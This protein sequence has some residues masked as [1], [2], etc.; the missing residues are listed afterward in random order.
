MVVFASDAGSVAA[1]RTLLWFGRADDQALRT[2][3]S[4]LRDATA[5]AALLGRCTRV[6]AGATDT[7]GL[8][9]VAPTPADWEDEPTESQPTAGPIDPVGSRAD[10]PPE[11]VDAPRNDAMTF[12]DRPTHVQEPTVA[13]PATAPAPALTTE[14]HPSDDALRERLRANPNDLAA[15]EALTGRLAQREDWVGLRDAYTMVIDALGNQSDPDRRLEGVLWQKV[16]GLDVER[17]DAP[18]TGASALRRSMSLRPT[19]ETARLL[20]SALPSDAPLAELYA[21]QAAAPFDAEVV[22]RLAAR[23]DADG[24]WQAATVVHEVAALLRGESAQGGDRIAPSCETWTR[25]LDDTTRLLLRPETRDL[26]LDRLF[27]AAGLAFSSLYAHTA[28]DYELDARNL[29]PPDDPLAIS[30]LV[31]QA[32]LAFGVD[33]EL[34]VYRNVTGFAFAFFERPAFIVGRDLV[35]AIS[36]TEMRFRIGMLMTWTRPYAFLPALLSLSQLSQLVAAV[37][38]WV[39]PAQRIVVTEETQRV[40]RHL[41]TLDASV[42]E[43]L[44]SA[45]EALADRPSDEALEAWRIGLGVEA[46][47]TGALFCGDPATAHASVQEHPPLRSVA[48]EQRWPREVLQW[49]GSEGYVRALTR[50]THTGL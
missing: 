25:A 8:G 35:G 29:L 47:R 23:L 14:A 7:L 21:C 19:R 11:E 49:L 13:L 16:G 30:V 42:S 34:Y 28:A 6:E 46:V 27:T 20:A 5:R 24:S 32:S 26:R 43:R 48:G 15:L 3:A 18:T 39:A 45:V 40:R 33:P 9:T 41:Q 38:D 36:Q 22:D 2:L 10:E 44:R 4:Q 12:S 1:A 50:L 37:C 31:R 17:L